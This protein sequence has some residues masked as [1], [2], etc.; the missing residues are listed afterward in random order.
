MARVGL[1]LSGCGVYDGSEIHEAVL[2]MLALDRAGAETVIMAPDK[3][4]MHVVDHKTGNAP[5]QKRNVLVEAARI[6]RGDIVDVKTVRASELDAVILPGG[7]GAAKNLS[8]FATD[9]DQCKV[10]EDVQSLLREMHA[11]GKP[12]AALCIAPAVIAGIFG[13]ELHPE[14]TIGNDADTV[15]AL[16]SMGA[17][18]FEAGVQEVVIDQRNKIITTPCYMLPARISDIATGA[19]KAV[20]ALLAMAGET[21]GATT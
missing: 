3:P 20:H 15:A 10:D 5:K 1:I 9:G 6:A 17:S 21:A 8:T 11:E 12:I 13:E 4:Q 2:T 16:E 14:I 18:H 7:Y 19:E